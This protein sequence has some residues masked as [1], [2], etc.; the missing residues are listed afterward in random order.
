MCRNLLGTALPG[1]ALHLPHGQFAKPLRPLIPPRKELRRRELE[2]G[3]CVCELGVY[4][5]G[6]FRWVC[7]ADADACALVIRSAGGK[8]ACSPCRVF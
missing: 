1:Q 8:P 2:P 3:G 7:V 5:R 6:S 4:C